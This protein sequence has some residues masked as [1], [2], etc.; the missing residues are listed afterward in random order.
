METLRFHHTPPDVFEKINQ[1]LPF[2]NAPH[3]PLSPDKALGVRR[4]GIPL[5]L[6]ASLLTVILRGEGEVE[7]RG[8]RFN[9]LGDQG[10]WKCR[11]PMYQPA[12]EARFKGGYE[13]EGID[14]LIFPIRAHPYGQALLESQHFYALEPGPGFQGMTPFLK[15]RN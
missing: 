5:T 4:W 8:R 13:R 9:N 12:F 3:P 2:E 1:R 14:D 15:Y 6:Y 11:L 10:I 7:G